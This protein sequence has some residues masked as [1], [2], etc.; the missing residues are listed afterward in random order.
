MT[1][2]IVDELRTSISRSVHANMREMHAFSSE[3][4]K[5]QAKNAL[6]GAA[7]RA[8]CSRTSRSVNEFGTQSL[9]GHL[10]DIDLGNIGNHMQ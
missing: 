7:C 10:D 1:Q 8:Q 6:C 3:S 9:H 2:V 4:M 5:Q